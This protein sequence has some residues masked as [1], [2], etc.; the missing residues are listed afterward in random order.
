VKRR[1]HATRLAA[2]LAA[3]FFLA[4]PGLA[5]SSPSA[6]AIDPAHTQTSFEVFHLT[7]ARYRA[8]LTRTT[9]V[10][11]LDEDHPAA[12]RVEATIDAASVRTR[13]PA[14]DA[15][16]RSPEFLDAERFPAISFRSTAVTFAAGK[17]RIVGLLTMHG[18]TRKAI[19]EV[20]LTPTVKDAAGRLRRGVQ[21]TTRINR[22]D[23]GIRWARALEAGPVLSDEVEVEIDAEI[24]RD[25]AAAASPASF[26]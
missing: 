3:L 5:R 2:L 25:E 9:G 1:P 13:D 23:Y 12:C 15:R 18:V 16:L 10:V 17:Y 26:P 4:S 24:V 20:T 22:Q 11:T 21:A 8:E 19:L 7:I 14:W 6:W